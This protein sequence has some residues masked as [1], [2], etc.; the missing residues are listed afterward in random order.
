METKELSLLVN[1]DEK[2]SIVILEPH[3]PL[4]KEGF[5]EASKK[6]DSFLEKGNKLN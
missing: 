2:N 4:T 6:V 1:I 5:E 3:G